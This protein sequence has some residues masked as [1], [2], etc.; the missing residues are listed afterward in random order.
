LIPNRKI[1]I[2][3]TVSPKPGVATPP[4]TL[5]RTKDDQDVEQSLAHHAAHL[6]DLAALPE[7]IGPIPFS[8]WAVIFFGAFERFTYFGLIA[9]WQNYMQHPPS[10]ENPSATIPG[11]LGLGQ[12]T[13]TNISNAFFLVSFL[14]PMLFAVLSDSKLGRYKT[15]MLGLGCY[16]IGCVVLVATSVGKALDA[17]AGVP[18]LAVAMVFVA[19][20]AGSVKACFVPFLGDQIGRTEK[21]VE[22]SGAGWVVVSPERTLQFVYNA[23]YW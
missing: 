6:S 10:H 2:S 7:A 15:L 23:Y 22:K 16:L 21:R 1:D 20:G 18:G 14:T 8:A 9:P 17:G 12:A 19:L 11:A 13:A 3:P 5:M 4:Q